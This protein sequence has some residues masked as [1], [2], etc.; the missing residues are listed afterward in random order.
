MAAVTFTWNG[1]AASRHLRARL[2]P[3]VRKAAEL[4]AERARK[5]APVLSGRLRAS[6]KV[7]PTDDPLGFRVVADVPYASFVEFGTSRQPANP[8][9]RRA[10]AESADAIRDAY[11][12]L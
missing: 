1:P 12:G 8:F 5:R 7:V 3:G 11:R 10:L 6:I 9:L 4:V 2:A